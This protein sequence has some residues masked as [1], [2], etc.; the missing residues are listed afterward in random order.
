MQ[1][2]D[3]QELLQQLRDLCCMRVVAASLAEP[4]PCCMDCKMCA[5]TMA[6]LPTCLRR[7]TITYLDALH[8]SILQGVSRT[9]KGYWVSHMWS[10][11][12]CEPCMEA[13]AASQTRTAPTRG[14]LLTDSTATPKN[15]HSRNRPHMTEVQDRGQGIRRQGQCPYREVCARRRLARMRPSYLPA[16]I[17]AT[18]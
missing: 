13:R 5:D 9:N 16:A 3:Y 6:E 18:G 14:A 7:Q 8:E 11:M 1:G 2:Q 15:A 4:W 12:A 17:V 10:C